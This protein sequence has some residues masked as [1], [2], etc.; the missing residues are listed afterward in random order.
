MLVPFAADAMFELVDRVERYPQ[1]LPWCAG[2]RVLETRDGRQDRAAS[3]S[4]ITACARTSR[5]TTSTAAGESIVITLQDGPFRHL[6]GEWR[7]VALA[8]DALQGRVRARLR[9]RDARCSSAS[10]VR[11]SATSRTRSSTR[12]CAAPK[13]VYATRADERH[14]RLGDARACRT[15]CRV[16]AAGGRDGRRRR[17]AIG[18]R[19]ATTRSMPRELALRGASAGARAADALLADGDRVELTRPL[20][21]RSEGSAPARARGRSRS[22]KTR[23]ESQAQHG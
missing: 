21:R 18:A 9:V 5:P 3:T 17:R 12:S 16:D 20:D 1:F 7:F 19:R 8:P 15:S 2:A 22:P 11:C 23:A 10:S 4:T 14:R 13:R 6:H